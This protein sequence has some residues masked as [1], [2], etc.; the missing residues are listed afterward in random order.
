MKTTP[1]GNSKLHITRLGFGAWAAG[2]G[3]WQFGWSTQDDS[4]SIGAIHRALELGINWI[5]TAAVYGLGHSEEIVAA[6]LADWPGTRPY[7]FT[8]CG[9]IWNE[10]REIDYSLQA[11]SSGGSVRTASKDLRPTSSIFTK[12]IGLRTICRRRRKDGRPWPRC[13]RKAKFALSVHRTSAAK[14]SRPRNLSHP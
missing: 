5:D 13:R 2:G 8:K 1:L 3:G 10:N 9:M 14:N 11:H 4:A 7:V 12:F 6:A